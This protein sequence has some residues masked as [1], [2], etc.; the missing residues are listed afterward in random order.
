MLKSPIWDIYQA[1]KNAGFGS[2]D[3]SQVA[4]FVRLCGRGIPDEDSL[5][6]NIKDWK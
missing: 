2:P 5:S 6:F 4:T 1:E 3:Y